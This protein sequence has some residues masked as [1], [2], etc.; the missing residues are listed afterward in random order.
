MARGRL[1]RDPYEGLEP[2]EAVRLLRLADAAIA[3]MTAERRRLEAEVP[4]SLRSDDPELQPVAVTLRRAVWRH[5]AGDVR[6]V[7]EVMNEKLG[8]SMV[9][10][11]PIWKA[12]ERQ[13][14]LED[15][16][17]GGTADGSR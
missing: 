13:A 11:F 14:G 7:N 10:R 9:C 5:V 6:L 2:G 8:G 12:I 17:E 3:E 1:G 4:A 16:R 15:V